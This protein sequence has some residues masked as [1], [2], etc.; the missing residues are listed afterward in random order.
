M[1]IIHELK[2]WHNGLHC[3]PTG[4][5]HAPRP[6]YW[7]RPANAGC[8]SHRDTCHSLDVTPH[9]RLLRWD[10]THDPCFQHSIVLPNEP[11]RQLSWLDSN[12]TRSWEHS[13]ALLTS[14]NEAQ[15]G[16]EEVEVEMVGFLS[17]GVWHVQ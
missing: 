6:H 5:F 10:L 8:I 2:T 13:N 7:I 15:E 1:I 14:A 17:L 11:S 12:H 16:E 9:S 3:V 4:R